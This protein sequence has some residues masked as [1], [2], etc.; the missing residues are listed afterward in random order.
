MN[1]T[2]W[3]ALGGSEISRGS[4]SG[5]AASWNRNQRN[6]EAPVC[7]SNEHVP[8]VVS[9]PLRSHCRTPRMARCRCLATGS[10]ANTCGF[11]YRL[12]EYLED[13]LGR[14]GNSQK[15]RWDKYC[16]SSTARV[17][18]SRQRSQI[19]KCMNKRMVAWIVHFIPDHTSMNKQAPIFWAYIYMRNRL[20]FINT[21]FFFF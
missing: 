16:R 8:H 9:P 18:Q 14:T 20:H 6:D 2:L 15:S 13:T 5:P 4:D 7:F 21:I 17:A 1:G 11:S 10:W 12:P 19:S 3:L